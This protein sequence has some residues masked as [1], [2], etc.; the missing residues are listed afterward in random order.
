MKDRK[1]VIMI[2]SACVL[3]ASGVALSFLSFYLSA[4]HIIHDSVLW[5]FAQ[6]IVYASSVFGIGSYVHY[7]MRGL[8]S[9]V[10]K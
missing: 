1:D 8:E 2:C 4:A 3:L 5:Y 9:E 6:T 10:K 7:K